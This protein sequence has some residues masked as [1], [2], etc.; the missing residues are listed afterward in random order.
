MKCG[1]CLFSYGLCLRPFGHY[2]FSVY[3]SFGLSAYVS[4]SLVYLLIWAWIAQ[5]PRIHWL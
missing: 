4:G 3:G 2:V 5:N 1:G